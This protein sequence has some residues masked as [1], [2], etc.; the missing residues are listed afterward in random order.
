MITSWFSSEKCRVHS[1]RSHVRPTCGEILFSRLA[2]ERRC[3][4]VIIFSSPHNKDQQCPRKGPDSDMKLTSAAVVAVL[5]GRDSLA[6]LSPVP[7]GSTSTKA[8]SLQTSNKC[9]LRMEAQGGGEQ[10]PSRAESLMAQPMGRQQMLQSAAAAA[11]GAVL[12]SSRPS[13]SYAADTP[14]VDF[15][16]VRDILPLGLRC[17]AAFGC[18]SHDM[19]ALQPQ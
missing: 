8:S 10:M 6:F 9:S 14:A 5:S 13:R 18:L 1:A 16:K 2:Q 19:A 17:L 11:F 7:F 4:L 12:V 3:P 15:Q